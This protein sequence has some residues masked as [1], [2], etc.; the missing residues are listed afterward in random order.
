MTLDHFRETRNYVNA[1]IGRL[2]DNVDRQ[3]GKGVFDGYSITTFAAGIPEAAVERDGKLAALT[4]LGSDGDSR[5]LPLDALF[6]L[7]GWSPKL[8]PIADWGLALEKKQVV[9]NTASFETSTPGIFAVGDV[10]TYPGK[11]KLIV[12]G[13][14]EATLAAFAIGAAIGAVV[15]IPL[16]FIGPILGALVVACIEDQIQHREDG[17][18]TENDSSPRD[19]TVGRRAARSARSAS[20]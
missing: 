12:C 5:D 19:E 15:A 6:V 16:P 3:R 10:N 1:I 13:F 4:L 7:L 18:H 20:R 8:G 14:H 9:V 11:Q 17:G 2:A